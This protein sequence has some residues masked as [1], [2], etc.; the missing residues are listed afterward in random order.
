MPTSCLGPLA[1]LDKQKAMYS[2]AVAALADPDRT[3][4]LLVARPTRSALTEIDRTHREL[5]ALGFTRQYVV[6]NGV[7]PAFAAE[8]DALGDA[9]RRREQ[10]ALANMPPEVR[11][12]PHDLIELKPTN[13]VGVE[14]LETLFE[15]TTPSP[16][17]EAP[18][19]RGLSDHPLSALIDDIERDGPCIVM[20]MGKGGVGKTTVAAAVAVALAERGHTVHLSTTDP[21]AH[22]TETLCG[23]VRNLRVSRIDPIAASRAYREKVMATKGARLGDEARESLAEDLRSPCN[24]EVA[25]FQEFS[26]VIQKSRRQF[27]VLDTAPTGH[28]LLLLDTTGAYHP[29]ILRHTVRGVHY[30]TP[31]MSLQDKD[32]TKILMITFAETTPVLEAAELQADLERAG[33]HPW[34]WIINTS[35]AAAAPTTPLLRHRATL[36]LNQ[37]YKVRNELADRVAVTP[38]ANEPVGI[39]ALESLSGQ[40]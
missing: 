15:P 21:A 24:D 10:E 34:A 28:T 22:L 40:A 27:V 5:A 7:L 38:V 31:L 39:P 3:R 20:C 11:S 13:M 26:H 18:D 23:S 8:S 14:A 16:E 30:V 37:I 1:G 9:V 6:V 25:V 12:L 33:I 29:E 19:L 17:A 36:E 4:L 2:A 35:V 32:A